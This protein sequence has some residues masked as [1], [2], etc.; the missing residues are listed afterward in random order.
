ML[1]NAQ[2]RCAMRRSLAVLAVVGAVCAAGAP[3]AAAA[4]VTSS[5][6]DPIFTAGLGNANNL[7]VTQ[8][9]ASVTFDDAAEA[10]TVDEP[11]V[12][13]CVNQPLSGAD[14]TANVTCTVTVGSAVNSVTLNLENGND[15]TTLTGVTAQTIQNGGEGDDRLTGGD[16]GDQLSGD[17]GVDVLRGG[18]G[19]DL[20]AGGDGVD[21]LF[22]DAGEDF[23][24]GDGGAD[25]IHGG[26]GV[27]HV[28]L[29]ASGAQTLTL[30]DVGDDGLAREGD[31][32]HS[33]VEDAATSL[34]G[35]RLVGSSRDNILFGD[36][37]NDD[38]TGRGGTDIL[39]GAGGEDVIRARDGIADTIACGPGADEVLADAI[40]TVLDQPNADP[41]LD[42]HCETVR[43]PGRR[44]GGGTTGGGTTTGG[45]GTTGSAPPP[46]PAGTPVA[47][48]SVSAIVS[49]RRDR[50][51]PYTFKIKGVVVLPPGVS[52]ARGCASATV[53]V[54]G[55]RDAK[56]VFTRTAN[57]KQDCTYAVKAAI[58]RKGRLKVAARFSGN[59]VLTAKSS[60]TRTVRA[61]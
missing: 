19:I 11:A 6:D 59:G 41:A 61:G 9:G 7:T 31:N 38:I 5:A 29:V 24:F 58:A 4:V 36:E 26:D 53:K 50:K 2:G 37:G 10:V 39:V 23:L 14:L 35:D 16:G 60:P 52:K 15:R 54:T 28:D 13:G 3:S 18:G 57:L 44:S 20:L 43:L 48:I 40:D 45:G 34:G 49:P 33:D 56:T 32:V 25:D 42:E 46:P 8:V 51:R 17:A 27:D 12:P 55:R 21:A 30:D 22:G 47:P 1:D